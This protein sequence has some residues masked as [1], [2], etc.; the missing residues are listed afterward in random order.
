MARQRNE[1]TICIPK[2]PKNITE[3]WG[4]VHISITLRDAFKLNTNLPE[5]LYITLPSEKLE[6][7]KRKSSWRVISAFDEPNIRVEDLMM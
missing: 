1:D 5:K 7:A 6:K 3:G 2:D 4:W